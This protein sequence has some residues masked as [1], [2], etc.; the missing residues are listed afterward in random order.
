MTIDNRRLKE[1]INTTR[2]SLRIQTIKYD[3]ALKQLSTYMHRAS[4]SNRSQEPLAQ[5]ALRTDNWA[6]EL[7]SISKEISGP[8]SGYSSTAL[9]RRTSNEGRQKS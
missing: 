8:G 1:E 7:R 4:H 2:D 3:E 9:K 6:S 5:R